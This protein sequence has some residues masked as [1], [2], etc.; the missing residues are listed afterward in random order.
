MGQWLV[1][2]WL[3]AHVPRTEDSRDSG[4][5]PPFGICAF[6]Y[7]TAHHPHFFHTHTR[8]HLTTSRARATL[9]HR[10]TLGK[11]F[12]MR[13]GSMVS[14]PLPESLLPLSVN[15]IYCK[16]LHVVNTYETL[17]LISL[18]PSGLEFNSQSTY[19]GRASI[20][21]EAV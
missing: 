18:G 11:Q 16:L 17:Y 14:S 9:C 8:P 21:I 7:R 1:A 5:S 13:P 10:Y 4:S 12:E 20:G 2:Q 6:G 15:S 3:V 19:S